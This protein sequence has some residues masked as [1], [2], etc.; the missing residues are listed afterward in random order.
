MKLYTGKILVVD[1]TD[2]KVSTEPLREDWLKDYWGCWGLALRYYWELVSPTIDPLSPQNVIVIMTGPFCG[3]LV[4][5]TSRFCLVSKSPQTGTIFETNTGGAFGPELK[6]AGYDGII[7]K[8]QADILSYIKI[9]DD[10]V[11]LESAESLAGKGIFETEKWLKDALGSPDAKTMSIGP[12]GENLIKYACIGTENY[13]Q[14]GRGG[15]GALFGSKNLKGIV[16]RGTGSISVADMPAFLEKITQHKEASVLT[17]ANLWASTDGTPILVEAMS[18]VGILPTRN[19]TYG[20]FDNRSGINSDA[21]KAAKRGDRACSSCPLACGKFTHINGAEMEGPEYETL[22]LAGS[23]C[24]ID[25]LEQVI[26]FN[27]LCDDFGLDTISCGNIVGLAMELAAKG[28]HDFGLRFGQPRAYL[29]VVS[30]IAMLS[31]KR[32]RE[33]ALGAKKLAEKYQSLDLVADAKGMEYPA[34]EPRGNYGMGLAYATSERGACHLRAFTAFSEAPLDIETQT[35]KVVEGQ[36][37]NAIKWSMCICDFWGSVTHE[38]MAELL[39]VA[40]GVTVT[41]DELA[42]A[43]ERIWNLTRLF[44]LGAGFTSSDDVLPEKIMNQPLEKGPHAGNVFKKEDFETARKRYYQLRGWD[45][46]GVPSRKKL[47]QLGLNQ[48]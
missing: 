33:L 12:A 27:R 47:K 3:T 18:E 31:T 22:C 2:K 32:G 37:F 42:L 20:V 38:I 41:P 23:N 35:Q 24:E 17:D 8:G 19:F 21:I 6:F 44:N 28:R 43:G 11:S 1:L 15:A 10:L 26:R 34:Y 14:M 46:K 13:R 48:L 36:N 5:T 7:I 40:L 29:E 4:P 16:C 45:E 25:D 39:T 9:Q 30:E